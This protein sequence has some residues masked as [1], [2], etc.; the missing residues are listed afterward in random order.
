MFHG[1]QAS[2]EDIFDSIGFESLISIQSFVALKGQIS[3]DPEK[4]HFEIK[5]FTKAC[6]RGL[7]S[8]DHYMIA[9]FGGLANFRRKNRQFLIPM[10]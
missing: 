6:I 2:P 7:I 8:G 9:L 1:R 5:N 3:I 10:Q 4:K